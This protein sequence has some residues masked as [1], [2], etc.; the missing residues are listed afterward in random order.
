MLNKCAAADNTDQMTTTL[1][2]AKNEFL[3]DARR[4]NGASDCQAVSLFHLEV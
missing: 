4:R 2:P 3:V 1:R